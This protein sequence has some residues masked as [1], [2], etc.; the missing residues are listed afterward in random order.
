M[1][2]L[3]ASIKIKNCDVTVAKL[4]P[5]HESDDEESKNEDVKDSNEP[6]NLRTC[7]LV[8]LDTDLWPLNLVIQQ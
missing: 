3:N 7:F 5:N 1:N 8:S 4:N 2:I 6:I